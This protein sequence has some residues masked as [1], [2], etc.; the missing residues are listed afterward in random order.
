MTSK[1]PCSSIWHMRDNVTTPCPCRLLP[2]SPLKV[3]GT[4]GTHLADLKDVAQG[5]IVPILRGSPP[6]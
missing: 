3:K 6:I 2:I 5:I 4:L 1:L